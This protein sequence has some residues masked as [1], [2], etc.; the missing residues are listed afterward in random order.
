MIRLGQTRKAFEAFS[1]LAVALLAF[2]ARSTLEPE[3]MAQ[4]RQGHP[5]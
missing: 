2:M 4:S 1:L 5:A 3:A